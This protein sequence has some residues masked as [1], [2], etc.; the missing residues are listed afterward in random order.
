MMGRRC[1][2]Q[3]HPLL[4][5]DV[6]SPVSKA[7]RRLMS[8]AQR[9]PLPRRHLS[10]G[11][12]PLERVAEHRGRPK[13]RNARPTGQVCRHGIGE[14]RGGAPQLCPPAFGKS[15]YALPQQP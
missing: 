5:L 12:A 1:S 13:G 7:T 6:T 15:P 10:A 9:S 8:A 2:R 14:F 11:L 4:C 3:Q